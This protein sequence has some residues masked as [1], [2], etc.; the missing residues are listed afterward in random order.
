MQAALRQ[1]FASLSV[2]NFRLYFIGQG[3]S[4]CGTWMQ[5]VALSLL[6]L[7]LTGS[8]TQLG[9]VTAAQFVPVLVLGLFGGIIADS[10]NKRRLLYYTQTIQGLL[11]CTL[12]VLTVTHHVQLWEVYAVAVGLGLSTVID[13]PSRQTFVIEMV[14]DKLLKNAVTLN[15]IMINSARIIG[16]TIAASLIASTGIGVCFLVN[17]VSY[18]AVLAAL[19]AM[20]DNELHPASTRVSLREPGQIRAGLR[21]VWSVPALRSTLLMMFLIGTFAYEFQVTLPLFATRTLHGD[22]TTYSLM[23]IAMGA[24][25]IVGGL[26]SAGRTAA[27]QKR[28]A[29]A[30]GL[31]GLS[32]I[33]TAIAPGTVSAL[34]LLVIMG[35]LSVLFISLGNTTLQLTSKPEM[36]GR[37][38]ALWAI[39]FAGT[40]PFG[41]P[42]IGAI[43]DHS[44]PRVGI[45]VGGLAA[46]IAG[47]LGMAAIRQ[48]PKPQPADHF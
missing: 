37:V 4:M 20:R 12:G 15:S 30:A 14:G 36:R 8:G 2:Y 34:L 33:F 41:G 16:P 47:L 10:F 11:A 48:T 21:Y 23:T 24:G 5:T 44:T 13:N 40:T 28:L 19:F 45:A 39:A 18:I 7:H 22:A 46:V 25:A 35:G 3:I 29:V 26:Y 31:F 9:L 17:G 42:I 6:V 1:T 32:L 38:M 27:T 43:T